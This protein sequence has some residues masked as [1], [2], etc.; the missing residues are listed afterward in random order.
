MSSVGKNM[1]DFWVNNRMRSNQWLIETAGGIHALRC[2]CVRLAWTHYNIYVCIISDYNA[3][4]PRPSSI[5]RLQPAYAGFSF[6]MQE[7]QILYGSF[8][9]YITVS[10]CEE[11]EIVEDRLNMEIAHK[12]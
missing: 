10:F 6:S 7:K 2:S 4:H 12:I 5:E 3:I 9:T 8:G 1:G 11:S